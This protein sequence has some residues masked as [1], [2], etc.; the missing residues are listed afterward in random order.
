M[1]YGVQVLKTRIFTYAMIL[2]RNH[3]SISD[4]LSGDHL[5]SLLHVFLFTMHIKFFNHFSTNSPMNFYSQEDGT[6]LYCYNLCLIL[7]TNILSVKRSTSQKKM[8][9][10]T[11]MMQLYLPII[12]LSKEEK[13]VYSYNNPGL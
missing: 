10:Q 8:I 11:Y 3:L 1:V 13:I 7:V 5:V 4:A 9:Y 12:E 2:L 6:T